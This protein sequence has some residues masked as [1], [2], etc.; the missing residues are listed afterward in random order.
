MSSAINVFVETHYVFG[1]VFVDE[2]GSIDCL[3][4]QLLQCC[5][6]SVF[7]ENVFSEQLSL[8]KPIEDKEVKGADL[9]LRSR[10]FNSL[11]VFYKLLHR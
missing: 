8:E 7:V 11:G 10:F 6:Q 3:F 1:V 2:F 5:N 4:L 9:N